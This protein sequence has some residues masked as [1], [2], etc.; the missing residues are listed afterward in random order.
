MLA[1]KRMSLL[2][3]TL[4]SLN[5]GMS[6]VVMTGHVENMNPWRSEIAGPTVHRSLDVLK[7]LTRPPL[8]GSLYLSSAASGDM[9]LLRAGESGG[10]A[11]VRF[12]YS[13]PE[14][15]NHPAVEKLVRSRR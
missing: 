4:D 13:F 3:L 10:Q 7:L 9:R 8:C 11:S 15:L 12:V 6:L 5:T 1:G 2:T 14:V